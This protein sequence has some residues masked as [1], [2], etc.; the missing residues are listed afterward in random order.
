MQ[1]NNL[2]LWRPKAICSS[3]LITGF[4]TTNDGRSVAYEVLQQCWWRFRSSGIWR[5]RPLGLWRWRQQSL[6]KFVDVFQSTSYHFPKNEPS[7]SCTF[8]D[9]TLFPFFFF[10]IYYTV[11]ISPDNNL[12]LR[13]PFSSHTFIVF[14]IFCV[15]NS[16]YWPLCGFRMKW[17]LCGCVVTYSYLWGEIAVSA[18]A[19]H[20]SILLH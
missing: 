20:I 15:P 3:D 8:A 16:K 19:P 7:K 9:W 17:A 5:P 6:S 14:V 13:Y 18:S 12:P 11:N 1:H 10:I 2:L 4:H